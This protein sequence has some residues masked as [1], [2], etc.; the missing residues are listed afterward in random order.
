M[1]TDH[2]LN[3]YT[4]KGQREWSA[5][6]ADHLFLRR[7]AVLS[8]MSRVPVLKPFVTRCFLALSFFKFFSTMTLTF[9][10][11]INIDISCLFVKSLGVFLKKEKKIYA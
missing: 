2:K 7:Y 4:Y 3:T 9:L 10:F 6:S 8:A 11:D 1:C 5:S